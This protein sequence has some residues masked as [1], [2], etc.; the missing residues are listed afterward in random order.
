VWLIV[1]I[2]FYCLL[3][4]LACIAWEIYFRVRPKVKKLLDQL[5]EGESG[6]VDHAFTFLV[7]PIHINLFIRRQ[8]N[9]VY[10]K[11]NITIL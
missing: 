9:G 8:I 1:E 11:W 4:N 7:P 3:A 5:K 2:L 6:E 10:Y